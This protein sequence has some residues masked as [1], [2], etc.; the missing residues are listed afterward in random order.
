[1]T[2]AER[3]EARYQRRKTA[4]QQKRDERGSRSFEDV[5]SF[6]NLYKAGVKSATGV[7]WKSS[8]QR[9]ENSI[10]QNTARTYMALMNNK[11]KSRGFHEFDIIE[12]GK[13]RHIKSVHISER[14]V[15]R[16]LCDEIL[17][18]V[19]SAGFIYDNGASLK[20]KGIDFSMNRLTAHMQRHFR[21]YGMAGGI[22]LFD[23]SDYFNSSRHEPIFK[24]LDRRIVDDRI[25]QL[26][27]SL[28]NDFGEVG[29]GL[30][31]QVSQ[32][33]ALMLPNKLDH[34]I[35]QGGIRGYARYMDD[36]YLIH[37]DVEY[38]KSLIPKLKEVCS[39][40]GINLNTKK[41]RIVPFHS[42]ARFLK[43]KFS[44][45]ES[46]LILRKMN[47]VGVRKMRE[48]L[49]KFRKWVDEDRFT[50]KDVETSYQSWRG[51]M[52]R[53]NSYHTLQKMDALY[54]ELYG[55]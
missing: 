28:I 11:W 45:T 6:Q 13:L 36:G 47:R 7:R 53:G 50:E 27:K 12:R 10:L 33:S 4:R 54:R 38:L 17:V 29:L 41:T 15:Q 48:K 42:G 30:G 43:T 9:Y 25:R 1:M 18:S 31:S 40:L 26:T 21:K 8:T 5:F 35:K 46:G 23:F 55:K 22:L 52:K 32:I 2:S 16:C 24:E 51:H 49:K 20:N 34:A 14:A 3:H 39:E 44:P 37:H 19:F